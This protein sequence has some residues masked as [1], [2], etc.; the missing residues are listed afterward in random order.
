MSASPSGRPEYSNPVVRWIE[1]RLPV[2]SA[3]N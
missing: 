3:A 1:Y 2:F